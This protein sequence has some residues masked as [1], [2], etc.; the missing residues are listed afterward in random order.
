VG[1]EGR[2]GMAGI[3]VT[4]RERMAGGYGKMGVEGTDATWA[5]MDGVLGYDYS[6]S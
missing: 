5:S 4:F 3:R 1:E 6:A 2:G